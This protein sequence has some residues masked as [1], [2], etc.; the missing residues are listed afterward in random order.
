MLLTADNVSVI[1]K[2]IWQNREKLNQ[3]NILPTRDLHRSS[4]DSEANEEQ[5]QHNT[6][7]FSKNVVFKSQTQNARVTGKSSRPLNRRQ[8]LV[9]EKILEELKIF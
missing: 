9:L 8:V 3:Y 1:C 5:P 6:S 7:A 4:N 2:N